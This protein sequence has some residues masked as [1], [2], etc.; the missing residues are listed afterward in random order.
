MAK[1]EFWVKSDYKTDPP[2]IKK[3]AMVA[4]DILV[5]E[6][7]VPEY[8][9]QVYTLGGHVFEI[10]RYRDRTDAISRIEELMEETR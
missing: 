5:T 1:K 3:S 7:I 6:G 8:I 4:F 2:A 9:V 10:A